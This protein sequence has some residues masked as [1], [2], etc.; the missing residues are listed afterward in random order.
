MQTLIDKARVLVEA[1]PWIRRLY[2]KTIVI[3]YGGHAMTERELRA[4]FAVDVVLLKYIGVRPVIV[5]GGGPQIGATLERMGK[6]SVF[7]DGL[8]VTDDETM[9]V[10]EMILGGT[11][12]QEIVG[13]VQQGG[14]RAIGLTGRDG[15]LLRV[16]KKLQG[17]RDLGRVGE[18]VGVDSSVVSAVAGEGFVPVI[19]PIGVDSGGITYNVNADEAAGAIAAALRA[20]KLILLTDVEG[21]KDRSGDLLRRLSVAEVRRHIEEKTIVGGMIP[22][23]ECC[24][25]ALAG[26]VGRTHIVDGR[27]LHA[28]L[29]E[30]FTD[31]GVG[32]LIGH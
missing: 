14:G 7:V 29:L 27:M 17:G 15:G 26:G 25:D 16:E 21:V 31:V 10:V 13:L 2:D 19:A 4:S 1:L 3:K 5:H 6:Q 28:V 22:K 9:A 12:N 11:I 18:V 32:T 24:I 23:V 20:E 8:R 30:I